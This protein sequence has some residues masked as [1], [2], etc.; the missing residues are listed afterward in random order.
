VVGSV[1][2]V[3]DTVQLVSSTSS[4]E[5]WSEIERDR[6]PPEEIQEVLVSLSYLPSAERLTVLMMKARNLFPQQVR[7]EDITFK[8]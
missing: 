2:V 3:M 5:V 6:K 4:V 1:K 7:R 8:C